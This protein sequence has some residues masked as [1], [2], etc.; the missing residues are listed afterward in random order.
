MKTKLFFFLALS[1]LCITKFIFASELNVVVSIKP[2]HSLVSGI[3]QGISTPVLLMKGNYSPHSYAIRP[4]SAED[5]QQADIVFWGGAK[6]E[7]FLTKSLKSLASR[8]KLVSLQGI[9]GL[10][11]L[12]MRSNKGWHLYDSDSVEYHSAE[13]ETESYSG[14]DPHVWLD[15]QNAKIISQKIVKVLSE[16]DPQNRQ[17]YHKNG[18]KY[19]LR[20]NLLD[21]DMKAKMAKVAEKPYLVFHDAYQYFERS[22]KLNAVG[23]VT[24]H[25]DYGSSARR[26]MEVQQTI[27]RERIIC[28]FRE[29]Q[30]SPKLL[31]TVVTG[32]KVKIGTLDPLG[33]GI[34]SGTELYFTL[35]NNLS[36]SLSKCLN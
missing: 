36:S 28:I 8:A 7:G 15:P 12:P 27:K 29:P 22:Y 23:S 11:L 18:E 1:I 16:M 31:Q 34:E 13:D 21:L 19:A 30:F 2:Y 9:E 25:I 14:T 33:V 6:L 26:L 32:T 24:L 17:K 10:K 20:L 3:M 5:L 35:L 4:S